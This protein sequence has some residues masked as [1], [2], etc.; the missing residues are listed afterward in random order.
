MGAVVYILTLAPLWRAVVYKL[1]VTPLWGWS[2]IYS[3]WRHCGGSGL[4]THIG[5]I[6]E[7]GGLYTHIGAVAV[8]YVLTLAPLRR[9][10]YSHW[11]RCGGLYT[12]I[13]T[14]AEGGGFDEVHLL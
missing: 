4:H 3:H 11:R 2:F 7:G 13:G 10:I 9:F 5:A 1:N 12:H 8:V 6:V 14:V